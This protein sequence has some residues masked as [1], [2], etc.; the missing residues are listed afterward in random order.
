MKENTGFEP[1]DLVAEHDGEACHLIWTDAGFTQYKKLFDE[2]EVECNGYAWTAVIESL[3]GEEEP[4]LVEELLFD[5][6][7]GMVSISGP[8]EGLAKVAAL[9]R[10]LFKDED[11]LREAIAGAGEDDDNAEF[12]ET[13]QALASGT[14]PSRIAFAAAVAERILPIYAH[15]A[16]GDDAKD[17]MAVIELGWSAATGANVEPEAARTLHAR[18]EALAARCAEESLDLLEV[19][20]VLAK[21]VVECAQAEDAEAGGVAAA[22]I[23]YAALDAASGVDETLGIDED[24]PESAASVEA[25]WLARALER[26]V[27]W[28]KP[29]TRELFRD[30][31][32]SPPPW[33]AAY[34]E[35]ED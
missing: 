17:V 25:E 27:A 10:A 16:P 23:H 15:S 6:E 11:A 18:L 9:V 4:D 24:A 34:A 21:S 29:V 8:R 22:R 32:S 12:E 33:L 13:I 31:G 28:K 2:A 19:C 7:A 1:F 35:A 20:V 3:V 14:S 5:P 26:T 30:L